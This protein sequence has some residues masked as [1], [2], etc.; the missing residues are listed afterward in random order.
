MGWAIV[1]SPFMSRFYQ[2]YHEK[3]FYV[4]KNSRYF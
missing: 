2:L 1:I 4:M 3:L